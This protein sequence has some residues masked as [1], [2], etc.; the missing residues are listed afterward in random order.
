MKKDESLN[1]A[2]GIDSRKPYV[3]PAGLV[4][5]LVADE[6]LGVGCKFVGGTG[7]AGDC[8]LGS[9]CPTEGS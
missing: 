7:Q 4:I 8:H 1:T 6:V 2:S 9:G 3:K 5:P